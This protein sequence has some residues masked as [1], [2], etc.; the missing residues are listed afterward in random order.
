[1]RVL[2]GHWQGAEGKRLAQLLTGWGYKVEVASRGGDAWRVLQ[3]EPAPRLCLLSCAL[4]GVDAL[5]LGRRI[6]GQEDKRKTYLL[7]LGQSNCLSDIRVAFDAGFDDYI[8]V[9]GL[10]VDELQVRVLLGQRVVEL[11]QALDPSSTRRG[12]RDSLPL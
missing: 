5:E 1:M 8:V 7:L 12:T 10:S 9:Q 2:L 6:R 4:T 11:Q 3:G